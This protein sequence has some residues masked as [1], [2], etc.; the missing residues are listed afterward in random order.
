MD[1]LPLSLPP[2]ATPERRGARGGRLGRPPGARSKRSLDLAKYIEA[3]FAGQTP[4]QQAA[5]LSMVSQKD[6]REA[7]ALAQEL[8]VVDVGLSPLMLAQV[9]KA[10]QLAKALNCDRRDAWLL[11][12]KEREGLMAYVHQKQAQ[13][14]D[15]GQA[16]PATVFLIP[17]GEAHQAQLLDLSQVDDDAI[18]FIDDLPDQPG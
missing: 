16:A 8:A 3:R 15:K 14:A 5:E 1:Q 11:L 12:Q 17:E 10:A 13:A 9:V 4:G 6:L 2:G 7:K 18:E